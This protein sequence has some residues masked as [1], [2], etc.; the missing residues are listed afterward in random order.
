MSDILNFSDQRQFL[1]TVEGVSGYWAM[2]TGGDVSVPN[3]KAFDG[4]NPTPGLVFGNPVVDDLVVTRNY[5]AARDASI[6]ATLKAGIA[7]AAPLVALITQ[8]PTDPAY[9]PNGAAGDT[10]QG[11]LTKVQVPSTD[12]TKSGASPATLALTFTCTKLT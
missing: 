2:L 4:G 9:S 5:S 8:V 7:A 10:W 11:T 6:S 3:D 1:V 12:A